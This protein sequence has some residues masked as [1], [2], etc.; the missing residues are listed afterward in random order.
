[1]RAAPQQISTLDRLLNWRADVEPQRVAARFRGRSWTFA[2]LRDRAWAM[3]EDLAA[4]GVKAGDG[5]AVVMPRSLDALVVC[6][7]ILRAGG[8]VLGLDVAAPNARNKTLIQRSGVRWSVIGGSASAECVDET[9]VIALPSGDARQASF[10]SRADPEKD[11]FLVFTS[12]SSG[13]PKGVRLS[14]AA[15]VARSGTE[16]AVWNMDAGDRYLM[17]TPLGIVGL[18]VLLS[19]LA[20]G[21]TLV[22]ADQED[23]NRATELARLIEEERITCASFPPRILRDFLVVPDIARKLQTLR[24][25]RSAGDSVD[26]AVVGRIGEILPACRLVDGYGLTES[27]G[28][29]MQDG[30]PFFGV[31]TRI[32]QE[33]LWIATPLLATAYLDE[34]RD[35]E[36]KFIRRT[37]ADDS[38]RLW[39]RT[40]DRAQRRA[41]GQISVLGRVDLQLNVDGVRIDPL[42]LEVALRLHPLVGDAAVAVHADATGRS[43][44]VAYVVEGTQ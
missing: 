16:L 7:A 38:E 39:Y 4:R 29:V 26:R 21:V 15:M 34:D 42:E 28:I 41:D 8:V 12:G 24:M 43:R 31:E 32:E 36:S 19:I 10:A 14:H 44:L 1:M 9:T 27:S 18:P 6:F 13:E 22:I 37:F 5:V 30:W 23:G 3:A 11:A 17:R 20:G 40:G 33:E 25:V 2:E 35:T